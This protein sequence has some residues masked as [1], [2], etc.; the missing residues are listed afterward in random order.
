MFVLT[1]VLEIKVELVLKAKAKDIITHARSTF[2]DQT[3]K[4]KPIS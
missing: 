4:L 3:A 1:S 2:K